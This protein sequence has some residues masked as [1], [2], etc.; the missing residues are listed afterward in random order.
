MKFRQ[1]SQLLDAQILATGCIKTDGS[2]EITVNIF[3][4]TLK[5]DRLKAKLAQRDL[6]D[7]TGVS[8][9]YI[10]QIELGNRCPTAP[11]IAKLA[12]ALNWGPTKVGKLVLQLGADNEN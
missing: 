11:I 6:E 8:N 5:R 9:V 2:G 1:F 7:L 4:E 3:G 10:S 12:R